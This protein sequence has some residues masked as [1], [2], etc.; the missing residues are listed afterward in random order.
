MVKGSSQGSLIP[1]TLCGEGAQ[2][3][4]K[5]RSTQGTLRENEQAVIRISPTSWIVEN[6]LHLRNEV[7]TVSCKWRFLIRQGCGPVQCL[8]SEKGNVSHSTT[9]SGKAVGL[10]LE[11]QSTLGNEIS[12]SLRTAIES[13]RGW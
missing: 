1:S 13:F 6:S 7:L 2:L 9:F 5:V 8:A 4:S 10:E 3:N 12:A 11:G